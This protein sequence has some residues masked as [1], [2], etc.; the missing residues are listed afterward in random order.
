MSHIVLCHLIHL[1]WLRH[2]DHNG[3]HLNSLRSPQG[4]FQHRDRCLNP[5][6]ENVA[7]QRSIQT[8]Q[9]QI[10]AERSRREAAERE[11]ELTLKEN[12]ALEQQL[13]AL[14]GCS[15]RQK[16]LE[17]EV[18]QLRLLWRSECAKRSG[19]N[20]LPDSLQ[21]KMTLIPVLITFI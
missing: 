10:A 18:E 13:T 12:V 3:L 6:E 14:S 16:E 7:L 19:L 11:R 5:E 20:S 4:S 17:A 1:V 8:L 9:A 15:T 21:I 2:L